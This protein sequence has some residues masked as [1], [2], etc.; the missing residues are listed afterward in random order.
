MD[1][2]HRLISFN[3]QKKTWR[4]SDR[5]LLAVSG[6][7]DSMVLLDL[8]QQLPKEQRPIIGVAH[9]NHHL[10]VASIEEEMYLAQYCQQHQ[11]PYHIAHWEEGPFVK[12]DIENQARKFRYTFFQQMM[13][14]NN[15]Q[16][17]V[18]GHHADDQSETILMRLTK[19]AQLTQLQ[20][21]QEVRSFGEGRLLRPLLTTEKKEL[22][23]YAQ[24]KQL[25]YFE[26]STNEKMEYF[27]NQL[28]LQVFPVLRQENPEIN[29][30]FQYFSKR[31]Q[32]ATSIMET[33]VQAAF[34]R[35]VYH[36]KL[37]CSLFLQE[38][39]PIQYMLL[40]Y[41]FDQ[42]KQQYL[43][44]V[45]ERQLQQILNVIHSDR[46]QQEIYLS[47]KWRFYKRYDQAFIQEAPIKKMGILEED[48]FSIGLNEELF[49]NSSEWLGIFSDANPKIPQ[50]L[51][52][53]KRWEYPVNSSITFPLKVRKR[54]AGDVLQYNSQGQH[55]KLKRILIDQKVPVENRIKSWVVTDQL[56]EILW[57]LPFRESYLSIPQETDK[58]QYRLIY[59]SK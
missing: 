21:M 55:K 20:G 35:C 9:V 6:G 30:Q 12:K 33:E 34:K 57:F 27:R 10:R 23:Y 13:Q 52:N 56:E 49:L 42:F 36:D 28:R 46:S 4:Q 11:I 58:I 14:E 48:S 53:W 22:Y 8:F 2:V 54:K 16:C 43:L 25:T 24:Q 41:W 47:K 19:G 39:E 51:K 1:L 3:L 32:Y 7:V 50:S 26:D 37:V 29:Q 40:V 18:T 15:Y 45:K 44:Q 38:S 59:L 5:L 31:I 17:L